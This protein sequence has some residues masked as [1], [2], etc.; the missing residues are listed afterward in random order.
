MA[1]SQASSVLRSALESR[2]SL[3]NVPG[4]PSACQGGMRFSSIAPRTVRARRV[5]SSRVDSSNGAESRSRWQPWQRRS[6]IG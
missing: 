5:K 3:T 6:T 2:R 4:G 1:S